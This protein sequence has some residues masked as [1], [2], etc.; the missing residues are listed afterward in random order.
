MLRILDLF[1]GI[2][3]FSLGMERT[4]GFKTIAFCESD[5]YA[6]R[7]LAKHWPD[8]PVYPDIR[9]F[10]ARDLERDGIGHPDVIT[11]GF[12]CQDISAAGRG[13][14]LSGSRSGLWYE[15]FRIIEEVHPEWVVVENAP[16]LRS[17]GLDVLLGQFASIG[18]DAEWHCIPAAA[19]GAWHKRDRIWIVGHPQSDGR[20]E[21]R[22]RRSDSTTAREQIAE[23][24]LSPADPYGPRLE[25]K[26]DGH[27]GQQQAIVGTHGWS[28]EPDVVRVVH[29]LPQRVDRIACLGNSIV[30]QIAT[31]IGHAILAA[32]AS[33][34]DRYVKG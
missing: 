8:V 29:G 12:P 25:I 27:A 14:G 34:N 23:R 24:P 33:A 31:L 7:V 11:G 4:G 13:A 3:G 10:T 6:T 28:V 22:A 1:S 18:Y 20:R 16:V 9:Q 21:R 2:G 26:F 32:E 17:R 30:P 19:V 15:M 5:P